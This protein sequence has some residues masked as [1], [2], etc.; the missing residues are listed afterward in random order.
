MSLG[1]LVDSTQSLL[2]ELVIL[3]QRYPLPSQGLLFFISKINHCECG[4][5][6]VFRKKRTTKSSLLGKSSLEV[7]TLIQSGHPR[8]LAII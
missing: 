7:A 6:R 2:S 8:I 1:S 3:Q 4:S 5:K